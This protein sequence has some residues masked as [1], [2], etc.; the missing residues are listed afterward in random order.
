MSSKDP[1]LLFYTKDFITGT[2][3]L[4]AAEVGAYIRLLCYAHQHHGTI[5]AEP[6]KLMRITGIIDTT[7]WQNIWTEV[8]KK[9]NQ[10]VNHSVNGSVEHLVNHSANHLVN[11]RLTNEIEKRKNHRPKK[12][13]SACLAG[14]ISAHKTLT[15]EQIQTIKT[16][17]KINDFIKI[18]DESEMKKQ[19]HTWFKNLVNQMV[20]NIANANVNILSIEDKKGGAGENTTEEIIGYNPLKSGPQNYR[21]QFGTEFHDIDPAEYLRL[22][23]QMFYETILMNNRATAA[24]IEQF[25]TEYR[26]YS[27]TGITHLQNAFKAAMQKYTTPDATPSRKLQSVGTGKVRDFDNTE[28]TIAT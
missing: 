23:H 2:Q 19:I 21:T 13:A 11:E 26:Y 25:N 20:N 27:F 5:P 17:F 15:R 22:R 9:F 4:S 10:M 12:Q 3:H 16:A 14:L 1:A 18:N 28:A 8:G 7:Q 24:H 6:E